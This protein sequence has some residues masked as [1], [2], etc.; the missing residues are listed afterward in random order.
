L[1][2][3]AYFP[4][5]SGFLCP[6][7][8]GYEINYDTDTLT[9]RLF[10]DISGAW[11]AF[12]CVS[13]DTFILIPYPPYNI[14]KGETYS[15]FYGDTSK[16]TSKDSLSYCL[17]SVIETSLVEELIIYPNPAYN[18]LKIKL[19]NSSKD[20]QIKITDINGRIML[21]ES[22]KSELDISSLPIG[23]YLVQVIS[24]SYKNSSIFTKY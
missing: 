24:N 5:G 13:V 23:I 2:T 19:R 11:P 8:T 4:L 6:E 18:N 21:K 7:L 1:E 9:L 3:I 20:D 14:I 17:T 10:Y 22:L 15:I 12:F 16:V